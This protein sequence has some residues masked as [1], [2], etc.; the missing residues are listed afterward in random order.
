VPRV[1]ATRRGAIGGM[2]RPYATDGPA[3]R[4]YR[5]PPDIPNAAGQA[6]ADRTGNQAAQ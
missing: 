1:G 2:G 3:Q 6:A 4:P 5:L